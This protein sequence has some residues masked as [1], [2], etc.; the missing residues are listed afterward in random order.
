MEGGKY[1]YA[2]Q[3]TRSGDKHDELQGSQGGITPVRVNGGMTTGNESEAAKGDAQKKRNKI[4]NKLKAG[5]HIT[6]E[7]ACAAT[8]R[9]L[10]GDPK[11]TKDPREAESRTKGEQDLQGKC[12]ESRAERARNEASH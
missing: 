1:R 9:E 5:K 4:T 12:K 8:R 3:Q 6:G 7:G 11:G 2:R 10:A